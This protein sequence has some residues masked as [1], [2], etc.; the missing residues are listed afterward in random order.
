MEGEFDLSRYQVLSV[1]SFNELLGIRD[2]L[3]APIIMTENKDKTMTRFLV[4]T[5]GK[6]V[7]VHEIKVDNYDAIYSRNQDD[8]TESETV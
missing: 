8:A 7:Y 5:D 4:L 2:T 1:R 6:L 3:Q